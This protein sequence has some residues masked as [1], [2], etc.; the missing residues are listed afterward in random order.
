[1][2]LTAPPVVQVIGHRTPS[3]NLQAAQTISP[4]LV[5][6]VPEP[7]SLLEP[8]AEAPGTPGTPG[9]P[10]LILCCCRQRG[11]PLKWD[12]ARLVSADVTQV[13]FQPGAA[14]TRRT[15][16]GGGASGRE[17]RKEC[18]DLPPL[19]FCGI[20]KKRMK[21]RRRLIKVRNLFHG[22][23][24]QNAG[25]ALFLVYGLLYY[26]D[27]IRS[28]NLL[29]LLRGAGGGGA[30]ANHLPSLRSSRAS[31]LTPCPPSL[32]PLISSLPFIQVPA[33]HFQPHRLTVP[34]LNRSKASQCVPEEKTGGGAGGGR[35]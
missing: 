8:L 21:R 25:R 22:S 29:L 31:S 5:P 1:M 11:N 30:T 9:T 18:K 20:L 35:D 17:R 6:S 23:D 34:G 2:S 24:S 32:H 16:P 19:S 15:A 28:L 26:G 33:C 3:L 27:A 14:T 10:D 13:T 4:S 12:K 7:L